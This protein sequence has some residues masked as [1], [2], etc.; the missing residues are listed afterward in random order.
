MMEREGI[1]SAPGST[2]DLTGNNFGCA[3]PFTYT[4]ATPKITV[5]MDSRVAV[6]KRLPNQI[7]STK[8]TKGITSSFATCTARCSTT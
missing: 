3:V 5:K 7:A 6:L 8:H 2:A 4:V 1:S